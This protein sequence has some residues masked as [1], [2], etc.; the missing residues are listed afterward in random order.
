MNP[1]TNYVYLFWN[2][3]MTSAE[4]QQWFFAMMLPSLHYAR[5]A[6]PHS[7]LPCRS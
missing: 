5:F 1:P 3:N 2:Q 4:S 7:F 6:R